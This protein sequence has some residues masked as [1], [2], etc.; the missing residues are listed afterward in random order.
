MTQLNNYIMY[1]PSEALENRGAF[2]QEFTEIEMRKILNMALPN[3]YCKKLFGID[4]NINE[5]TLLKT[6]DKFQRVESD[7]EP[8][9]KDYGN[10]GTKHNI[11]DTTRV[12]GS[13]KMT[14][15]TCGKQHKGECW[16]LKN[17][18]T[19]GRNE[20]NGAKVFNKKQMK[21]INQIFKSHSSNRIEESDF[22]SEILAAGWKKGINSVQQ[23]YIAQHYQADNEMCSD[24][25]VKSIEGNQLESLKK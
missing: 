25:D 11:D 17:S 18:G 13:K 8:A 3:S 20:R 7:K 24:E 10:K 5:Q 22:D 21:F 15:K 1:L 16:K 4:W 14:C 19:A 23:M 9:D 6:F 2:K 12:P